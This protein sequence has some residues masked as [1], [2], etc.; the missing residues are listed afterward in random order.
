MSLQV[1]ENTIVEGNTKLQVALVDKHL[2]QNKIQEAQSM[3]DMG[4]ERKQHFKSEI[5]HLLT[6][7]RKM[8]SGWA[9]SYCTF[10][11]L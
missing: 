9:A 7:R 10:S 1:A 2:Y 4:L 5:S 3:I 8:S 11:L 6:K